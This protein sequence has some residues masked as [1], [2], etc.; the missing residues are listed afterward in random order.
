M[1]RDGVHK[2]CVLKPGDRIVFFAAI[3]ETK[4]GRTIIHS[5]PDGYSLVREIDVLFVIDEGNPKI[6]V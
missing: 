4:Q 5:L 2:P 1:Y 6:E 3:L